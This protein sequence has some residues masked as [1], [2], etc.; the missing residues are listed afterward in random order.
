MN[1]TS[2]KISAFIL[3]CILLLQNVYGQEIDRVD[4]KSGV[5]K[6]RLRTVILTESV[7]YAS[8]LFYLNNVWY[9]NHD[10]VPFHFYND[11]PGW[12]Q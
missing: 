6:D 3:L 12:L 10:T 8:G 5:R 2:K 1:L 9:Q 7:I 11:F 4:M